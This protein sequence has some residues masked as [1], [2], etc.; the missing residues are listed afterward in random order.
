MDAS[1]HACRDL[2]IGPGLRLGHHRPGRERRASEERGAPLH[3][4]EHALV[5]AARGALLGIS[6]LGLRVPRI[7]AWPLALVGTL[8][9][10]L[11]VVRAARFRND[12]S[13]EDLTSP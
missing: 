12:A 11:G 9:G 5:A 4:H 7:L 10:A 1:D 2:R 3:T 13:G 8:F 6:L